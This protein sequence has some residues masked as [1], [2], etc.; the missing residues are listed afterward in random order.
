MVQHKRRYERYVRTVLEKLDG[1]TSS[2][3]GL[4]HHLLSLNKN[5]DAQVQAQLSLM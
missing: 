3:N 4:L 2:F 5:Y 1:Q